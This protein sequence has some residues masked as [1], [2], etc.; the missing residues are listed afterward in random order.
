[1]EYSNELAASKRQWLPYY[2]FDGIKPVL[3]T[4]LFGEQ[5][6]LDLDGTEVQLIYVGP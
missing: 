1:L 4:T 6:V 5:Y 2:D 3:P